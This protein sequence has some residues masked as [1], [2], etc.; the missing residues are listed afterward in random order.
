[1]TPT[2]TLLSKSTN[3][4]SFC[5]TTSVNSAYVNKCHNCKPNK[6]FILSVL[7]NWENIRYSL[8]RGSHN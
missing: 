1:M 2:Q 8:T 6:S 5:L 7:E 3:S 4:F